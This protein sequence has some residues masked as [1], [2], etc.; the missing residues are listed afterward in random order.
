[1]KSNAQQY[2]PLSPATLHILLALTGGELHGYGIMLEAARHSGGQYKIGPGTLYDNLKKL[3]AA[4]LVE[5]SQR[6]D[7][8]TGE[9]RKFQITTLGYDVLAA[10]VERLSGVL[11]HARRSIRLAER[12]S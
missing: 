11:R 12:R 5:E 9:R 7:L 8:E 2:L 10:E 6:E 4:G 1:M 3:L